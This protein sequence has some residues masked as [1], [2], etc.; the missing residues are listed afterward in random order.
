MTVGCLYPLTGR[1][2]RY[3]HD[4]IVGAEM[5]AEEVNSRGGILGKELRLLFADDR[6]DPTYA[7]KVAQRYILEDRVDFLMGVV[8]SAVALAVTQVSRYFQVMF[9]GTDHASAR[10]TLEAFQPFYFR[11][12]NNTMQSMRAGVIYLSRRP[13]RRFFYIGPDYEYG[14]R[15]WQDF[16]DYLPR[17]IPD[18]QV[19]G[20]VWPKLFERDY[21]PFLQAVLEARP[22]VLVAGFWGG[23]TITFLEQAMEVGLFDRVQVVSFDAG[24]NYEVLEALGDRVPSGLILSAR[25]HNN[26]PD[27]PANRAFVQGFWHRAR[28]YPSYTAHGAYVGVHFVARA[29]ERARSLDP[30]DVVRAGEGLELPTPR[31]R[32]GFTS[33]IRPVDHQVVQEMYIGRTQPCGELPPAR[34]L[35]GDWEVVPADVLLPTEE[36][37][38]AARRAAAPASGGKAGS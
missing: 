27:T 10:L 18:A 1:A 19:V 26:F 29:V 24:G 21:R 7:V 23:D 33:W 28:R 11:V 4:S 16:R 35:L 9:V 36:E 8:S 37:V 31:D 13:W 32:E 6:S 2:A 38:Q 25:H 20:S 5:A 34:Y 3:G 30:E 22:E 12:T 17:V 14:H 15:Q